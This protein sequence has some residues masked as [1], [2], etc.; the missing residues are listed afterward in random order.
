M[1]VYRLQ[2]VIAQLQERHADCKY[3][4]LWKQEAYAGEP[5]VLRFTKE[6]DSDVHEGAYVLVFDEAERY[7]YVTSVHKVIWERPLEYSPTNELE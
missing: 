3:W 6:P 5:V 1:A 4:D 2:D 7:G